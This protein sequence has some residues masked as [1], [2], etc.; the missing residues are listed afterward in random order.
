MSKVV[1]A[2]LESVFLSF[3]DISGGCFPLPLR[4]DG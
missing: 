4:M 3:G 2:I 1:A